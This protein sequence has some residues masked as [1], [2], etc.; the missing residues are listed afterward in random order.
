MIMFVLH[1]IRKTKQLEPYIKG[2]SFAYKCFENVLKKTVTL[3]ITSLTHSKKNPRL[4][5]MSPPPPNHADFFILLL[6]AS[7]VITLIPQ[8]S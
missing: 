5:I 8:C 7:G 4:G 2:E 6:G 1:T 3:L